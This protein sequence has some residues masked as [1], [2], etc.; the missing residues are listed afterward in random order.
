MIVTIDGPAGS[1]KSTAARNLAKKLGFEYLDTG[2]TYRAATLKAI[3]CGTDLTDQAA[4]ARL[5]GEMDLHL[6]PN[7]DGLRV[8]LDGQDVTEA[9]RSPEISDNAH[10]LANAPSVRE[11][12]VALQRKIGR[13]LG[14]F[15]TEGRDQG[16]VV[17]PDA[18]VKIYLDADPKERAQRRYKEFIARGEKTTLDAVLQSVIHRDQRDRGRTVGPLVKPQGAEVINTTG[19]SIEQTYEELLACVEKYR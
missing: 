9:I 1:G 2:A 11:V 7:A 10:Y 8:I 15:V 19:K 16:S 12:L 3:R 13:E 4:L 6:I 14:N 5:A 18:D 17:F